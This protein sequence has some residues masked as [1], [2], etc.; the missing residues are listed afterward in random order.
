MAPRIM[1]VA[2]GKGGVGKTTTVANLAVALGLQGHRVLAWDLDGQANLTQGLGVPIDKVKVSSYHLMTERL[3][4]IQRAVQTTEYENVDLIPS[5]MELFAAEQE[6]GGGLGKE[7]IIKA[8]LTQPEAQEYDV[9]LMDLPPNLGFHTVNGFAASRWVLVPLQM[10]GFALSGLRQLAHAIRLSQE[11]LNPELELLGLL[12]TFVSTR[13]T[14][15]RELLEALHMIPGTRVFQPY[16]PFTVRVAEGSLTGIP[17]VASGPTTPAGEA[18]LQA[19]A[20][21][22]D[23][24][25]QEPEHVD[26]A[27]SPR[28]AAPPRAE[29]VGVQD[30]V[31][32]LRG[33]RGPAPAAEAPG[34]IMGWLRRLQRAVS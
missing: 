21:I 17:V 12:P 6:L 18:Y 27:P 7:F 3:G 1:S 34:G 29:A 24:I 23:V 13:T 32:E 10:S 16:I 26:K 30:L 4:S 14:F 22:W 8:L 25:L 33:A 5:Q 19:A 28:I 31:R 20:N 15:S 2:S 11:M 9:V